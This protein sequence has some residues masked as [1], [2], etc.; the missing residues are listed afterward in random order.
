VN[1]ICSDCGHK[2]DRMKPETIAKG[3]TIREPGEVLCGGCTSRRTIM[4]RQLEALPTDLS[5]I[6]AK[7][8]VR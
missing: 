7:R 5:L 1:N 3:S 6:R 2:T 8:A 4:V